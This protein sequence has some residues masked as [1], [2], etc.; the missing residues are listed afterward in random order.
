VKCHRATRCE[1]PQSHTVWYAREPHGVICHRA[2]Q[3]H[4]VCYMPPTRQSSRALIL[5]AL[6]RAQI[7]G[8]D[9][10]LLSSR[11]SLLTHTQ[12]TSALTHARRPCH[13]HSL[14]VCVCVMLC[15]RGQQAHR[16]P[17]PRTH[18]LHTKLMCARK[19]ERAER[20]RQQSASAPRRCD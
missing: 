14:L 15:A 8:T 2:T 11:T 19:L 20:A 1:M 4:T 7:E 13:H 10:I 6:S 12:H 3:S 18:E 5:R 17:R 9:N 16:E